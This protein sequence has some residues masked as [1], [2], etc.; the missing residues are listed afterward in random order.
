MRRLRQSIVGATIGMIFIWQA[1]SHAQTNYLDTTFNP[2][3]GAQG[4]FVESMAIQSD[5]KILICGNFTSFNGQPKSYIAR[6][7]TNGSVDPNFTADVSYWVR[8][9]AVQDDGKIVIGGYF[10]SVEG[11]S[12][13][14]VARL[15][16][17]GSLD[18]N[19]V[20]GTG[21]TGSM[22][23]GIDGNTNAF[24]FTAAVQADQKILIAGNFTHYNGVSK[25]GVAR[26]NTNGTLDTT[27]VGTGVNNWVRSMRILDNG[28]ILLTGWF[29]EY[30]NRSFNRVVRINPDGSADTNFNAFF[31]DLTAVYTSAEL[32]DEKLVVGGHTVNSNSVFQQEVVRLNTNGTYDTNFNNGGSGANEK[33]QS[34]A[35]Q[36]DGKIVIGGFFTLYNGTHVDNFARLNSDGTLDNSFGANVNSW[37]WTVLV[38]EDGKILMCGGFSSVN[39]ASRNGVA[40][41]NTFP[42]PILFNPK[43]FPNRFEVSVATQNGKNYSLQYRDS[44]STT[45]WTP[46]PSIPGDGTIKTLTNSSPPITNR[47]Y[48]V[49]EN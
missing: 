41:L 43:R 26:L 42:A 33:V 12:R 17:D 2:G 14:L 25:R 21:C 47:F 29:T 10:L 32:P 18:T 28:Q 4:G 16:S 24:L 39:G 36:P 1:T 45:N 30:N 48:R 13:N 20:V 38:Q 35:V 19:F 23:A 37:I 40:R 5:G 31:G 27:F 8:Y 15:N 34:V 6:L 22:G 9:M 11:Q 46:L 49:L 3:T 7:N 44:I